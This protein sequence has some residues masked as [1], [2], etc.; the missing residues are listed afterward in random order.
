VLTNAYINIGSIYNDRREYQ[1][2]NTYYNQALKSY[3]AIKDTAG[4][5]YAFLPLATPT[6]SLAKIKREWTA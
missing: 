4:I 5:G 6:R 2:A 3:T 1:L